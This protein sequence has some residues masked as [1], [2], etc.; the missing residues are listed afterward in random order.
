MTA[1]LFPVF[2]K[3][4]D[5]SC[6][7]VGAGE[8]AAAKIAA[9]LEAGA[10]VTVVAPRANSYVREI[11]AAGKLSW[12]E[13]EFRANDLVGVFLVIAA[14][15]ASEVNR[16]VFLEA[17]RGGILTNAVDDPPH[18]DFYFPAVVRRGALQIAI[19]TSGESPALAQRLRRELEACLDEYLG[20]WVAAIGKLRREILAT[21]PPS[22]AR[23]RLLHSLASREAEPLNSGAKR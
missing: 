15:S 16:T 2:I 1:N 6:L 11:A 7:V 20:D 19:S 22:K 12:I 21:H 9:L 8:I 14:T 17:Q 4:A 18:C 5:R 10:R 23:K 3:L 13:R